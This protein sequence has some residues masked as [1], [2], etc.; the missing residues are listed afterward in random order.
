MTAVA[1][2]AFFDWWFAPWQYAANAVT[3][4]PLAADLLGQRDGY[5]LWCRQAGLIPD[6]PQ[7]ADWGWCAVTASSADELRASAALFGGL[8]AAREHDSNILAELSTADRKWCIGI[9]ATQPLHA[10]VHSRRASLGVR[11]MAELA[12]RLHTGFP[13]L[14]PRLRLMLPKQEAQ[15]VDAAL[16]AASAADIKQDASPLR[17]QRCWRL[18]SSRAAS[19]GA[20]EHVVQ[21][22]QQDRNL[23]E[24]V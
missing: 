9:A 22:P 10:T 15:A 3:V 8:I 4:L 5:R 14:W 23:A 21:E 20:A 6:L 7:G 17:A 11:G 24:L 19:S 12:R 16:A 2:D 13:G 18:C 1:T